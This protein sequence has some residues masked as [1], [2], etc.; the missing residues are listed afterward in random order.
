MVMKFG[1]IARRCFLFKADALPPSRDTRVDD[2]VTR[3]KKICFAKKAKPEMHRF[4]RTRCDILEIPTATLIFSTT[5][6]LPV[7][8]STLS[9]IGGLPEFKMADSKPE[10]E[11]AFERNVTAT[12]F[13]NLSHIF[14][15]ARPAFVTADIAR[16]RRT[17][18]IQNGG[19]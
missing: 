3:N 16:H 1:D 12:R 14:D 17:T 4:S 19:L 18:G 13:Q 15:H 11:I 6:D 10:V 5:L 7:S 2:H 8:L 9:D